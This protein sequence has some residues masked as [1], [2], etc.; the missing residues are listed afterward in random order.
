ME[1][2]WFIF[3][4][5]FSSLKTSFCRRLDAFKML[6]HSSKFIRKYSEKIFRFCLSDVDSRFH[7]APRAHCG[8]K[9]RSVI[10]CS[11][12]SINCFYR[13]K[14]TLEFF[15]NFVIQI[16]F[17]SMKDLFDVQVR[18]INVFNGETNQ[19]RLKLIRGNRN[20]ACKQ[21]RVCSASISQFE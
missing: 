4:Y 13:C 20:T 6:N 12:V 10:L 17:N 19:E 11:V 16:T 14:E 7:N 18:I 2:F 21:T 8:M 15:I 9:Y 5:S 1:P 3:N